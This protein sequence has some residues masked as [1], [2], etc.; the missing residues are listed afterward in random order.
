MF[1]FLPPFLAGLLALLTVESV[2]AADLF[3]FRD[4]SGRVLAIAVPDT[5]PIPATVD[6]AG[7]TQA[8][9]D[10]ARRFYRLEDLDVVDVEFET[11]PTRYWRVTFL[12]SERGQTHHLYA[13]VLP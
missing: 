13:V 5:E 4:G 7:A 8:A 3:A 10:W 9:L 6:Q 2:R 11:R 12:V 1:R